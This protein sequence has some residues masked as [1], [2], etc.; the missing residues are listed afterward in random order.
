MNFFVSCN[1]KEP[2]YYAAAINSTNSIK[3]YEYFKSQSPD[4][5]LDPNHTHFILADDGSQNGSSNEIYRFR[6][7]FENE[8]RKGI[9]HKAYAKQRNNLPDL[10]TKSTNENVYDG[11]NSNNE[12]IP[13]VTILVQ[14]D[15]PKTLK[16]IE[17]KLNS[18]VPILILAVREI[19]LILTKFASPI[20]NSP[21]LIGYERLR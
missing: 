5:L 9:T 3:N 1:N 19:V 16:V 10:E 6:L 8:L 17:E 20:N 12:L 13:M 2:V 15:G 11:Y 18:G 21:A 7:D 4:I 14:G